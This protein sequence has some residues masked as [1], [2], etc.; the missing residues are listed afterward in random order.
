MND[1][2][3]LDLVCVLCGFGYLIQFGVVL[4]NQ[5]V[6]VGFDDEVWQQ[7]F[8]LGIKVSLVLD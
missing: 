8:G 7:V 5:G 1:I 6:F 3:L 4:I 2:L